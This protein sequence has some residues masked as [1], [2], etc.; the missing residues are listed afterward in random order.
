[1]TF[2]KCQNKTEVKLGMRENRKLYFRVN[3]KNKASQDT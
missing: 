3:V 1:L 2:S